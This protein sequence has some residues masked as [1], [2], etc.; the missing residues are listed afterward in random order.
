MEKKEFQTESGIRLGISVRQLRDIK[1]EPDS[2]AM[3]NKTTIFYCR[4][5]HA[6]ASDFLI[7]YNMP[8][9]YADY[10]FES[11]LLTE[12]KFGFEYP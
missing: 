8:M 10:K 11:G 3:K 1:G 5:S 9:Y 2:I 6:Q 7:K 12:F 4:I